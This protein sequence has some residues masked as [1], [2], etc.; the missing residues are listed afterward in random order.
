[1]GQQ[2]AFIFDIIVIAVILG[3]TFAGAKKGF[4]KVILEMTATIIAVFC[5]MV[6][7]E[8][9][10]QQIY[11]S[12]VKQ[13]AEEFIDENV[14]KFEEFLNVDFFSGS[15]L[16]FDKVKIDGEYAENLNP[17]FAGT[18]TAV[19][20]L[21]NSVT[22]LSQTGLEEVDL[23]FFGI[24]KGTD[25][26]EVSVKT[27][28][29]SADDMKNYGAGMII[30]AE[31]IASCFVKSGAAEPLGDL[32]GELSKYLPAEFSQSASGVTVSAARGVLLSMLKTKSTAKSA[33]MDGLIEPNCVMAIRTILFIIIFAVAMVILNIVINLAGLLNK[34]PVLGEANRFLGGAAGFLEGASIVL[35]VCIITRLIVSLSGPDV[36][37]FN[38][39]AIDSTFLFRHI[40]NME[41]ISF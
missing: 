16:D 37:L 4:A 19:I 36:I 7:S 30:S 14:E 24:E 31:Y 28:E 9:L 22:D 12:F 10:A 1:M 35:I 40:Y 20:D 38:E 33:V 26:S 18:N 39:T 11:T 2:F 15:Q 21:S 3:L 17:D 5:A 27:I 41:L 29:I 34:V 8:P 32:L 23:S 6:F 25:L 13:P